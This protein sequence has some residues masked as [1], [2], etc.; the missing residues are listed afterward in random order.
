ML[1]CLLMVVLPVWA[2]SPS[3][4]WPQYWAHLPEASAE[5]GVL[6]EAFAAL[7]KGELNAELAHKAEQVLRP[8]LQA[9]AAARVG[10]PVDDEPARQAA[11]NEGRA[12]MFLGEL[13]AAQPSRTQ[14]V[15]E[16]ERQALGLLERDLR[17]DD[18]E[19]ADH[20]SSHAN[21]LRML[22][23]R[24]EAIELLKRA[25][26]ITEQAYGPDHPAVVPRLNGLAELYEGMA[27]YADALPLYRRAL[28]IVDQGPDHPSTATSLSNLAGLYR[29]MGRYE[30]AL[31]LAQRALVILEK[32]NGPEHP[33]T[34]IGL[35]N[36]AALYQDM[37]RFEQ[38][39]SLYQ[40]ALAISEKERGS[41]HLITGIGL[42]NLA[43][44]YRI[45]GSYDQALP[46]C[47]RALA[48]AEKAK[49]PEHPRTGIH[50]NNLALLYQVMGRY[51]QALQLA[52]R[53][54]VISDKAEGPE[55]PSTG[56]RL[57]NLA[58]LYKDM[59]SY[60]QALP[61]YQRALSISENT[62]G[63]EHS[64][65]GTILDSLAGLYRDMGSYEE[66]LPLFQRALAIAE[67]AN[68]PAH[69]STLISL[70]NLAVVYRDMGRYEQAL[71]LAQR[72]LIISQ[73]ALGLDHPSAGTSLNNL[74]LLYQ[75]M[76]R[77]KQA[78]LLYSRG[79]SVAGRTTAPMLISLLSG[80]MM[81]AYGQ[82][83]QGSDSSNFYKP[84]LAI[85]FGKQ[86]IQSLQ[87]VRS[88][89]QGLEKGLQKSFLQKHQNTYQFLASLL[90]D[91]GRLAEAEQVLTM[92]KEREL[93]ETVRSS[94]ISSHL[95]TVDDVGVE[96]VA[97]ERL[98]R[99]QERGSKDAAELAALETRIKQGAELSAAEEARRQALIV[100]TEAWRADFQRFFDG[101][102][103]L[104]KENTA[105]L[106]QEAPPA[107]NT[108]LQAKVALDPTGAVGL[109][110]VVTE[111]HVSIIVATP[112][113]SFGRRSNIKS[114]D[115][116][117]QIGAL[118]QAIVKKGDTREPAQALWQ[119]LIAP[120]WAD[121]QAAGAQTLVLSLTDKLRY[122]P[123]AA[124]QD[125][126]GRYLV[127]DVALTM[128]AQAADT[129]PAPSAQAWQ[130]SAL[131]LTQARE[132]YPA[133][134]GVQHELRSIVKTDASPQGV[135]PG[136][137]AFDE[138][139]NI[140]QLQ[141][142]LNGRGNVVHIAS[143][144]DF[145]PGDESR[146]VLLL[147]QGEPISLG[148]LAGMNFSRVEQL[149]LS[150]CET[151]MGGGVNENGVEV[152]S[153]AAVA[154]R[155]QAKSVLATL[156]KVADESTA[157]L[158]QDFYRQRAQPEPPSRAQALRAAQTA[159]IE[160]RFASDEP[161]DPSTTRGARLA[162]ASD[163]SSAVTKDPRKPYAHPYYWAPF[164]LSGSW[165]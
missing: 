148:K 144:F 6:N 119:A 76:G 115:L 93:T 1:G 102:D 45:M 123:F 152:E 62:N 95:A 145:K 105:T 110:Y 46:L 97:S 127:Q 158:M 58:R 35:N 107:T 47:Q 60:E 43:E 37:G 40:R 29:T 103:D 160:G 71:Q 135:L 7:G 3:P 74:A 108:R 114:S 165:L 51:E 99:L 88:H 50:L 49:G 150:A 117:R 56:A 59:A 44:L 32:S 28:V 162:G 13:A 133:L 82:L 155:A 18:L 96:K 92:L 8:M 78:S 120:V 38:A 30:Q 159:M 52:K 36:L 84:K 72:K 24:E 70:S 73:R 16:D 53:A 20:L 4:A 146:S 128:L 68:G 17:G 66:A 142:A 67:K 116:N 129:T 75:E 124:L 77:Y 104:F 137:I 139:F 25:L 48:I 143:H 118:R 163:E 138:Q 101:L 27:R 121:V 69:P 21:T 54:L 26:A 100:A 39:L 31:P 130:V 10:K 89:M 80:N 151:A 79:F 157:N 81:V 15:Y 9:S 125:P 156:W 154:L 11:L 34:G 91:A 122:L 141:L 113:G 12:W 149:T 55:H 126:K 14:Q 63:P 134:P 57:H 61:L 42:N 131:G 98:A 136:R 33:S 94:P 22:N 65:T 164:V 23:R 90:I 111:D 19:L 64:I 147:G 109:H 153:L 5:R 112:K 86:S 132:G 161:V 87:A 85:W 106:A 140:S 41:D 83:G 2:A